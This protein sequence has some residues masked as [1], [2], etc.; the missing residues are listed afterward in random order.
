MSNQTYNETWL[1]AVKLVDEATRLD[2]EAESAKPSKDKEQVRRTVGRL[3]LM[4]L[5]AINKLDLCYDQVKGISII[6]ILCIVDNWN[7]YWAHNFI[8]FVVKS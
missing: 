4:Y 6:N 1:A 8:T 7:V 5:V 3:Y 2:V